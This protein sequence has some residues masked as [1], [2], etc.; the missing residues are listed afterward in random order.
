MRGN[1]HDFRS[2]ADGI[3]IPYGIY[4][5]PVNRRRV[6]V[7]TSHDTPEFAVDSIEKWWRYEGRPLD[8]CDTISHCLA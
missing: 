7:G 3:A 2:E 1:D 4:D 6:F 8:S 5:R